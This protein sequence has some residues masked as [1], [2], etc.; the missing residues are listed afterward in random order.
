[1]SV[2]E[3]FSES[4]ERILQPGPW[5]QQLVREWVEIS[6]DV[7][8]RIAEAFA[9]RSVDLEQLS[10]AYMVNAE[11]FFGHAARNSSWTWHHL[12]SLALTSQLLQ[13]S[14][15][16]HKRID[17]LLYLGGITAVRMPKLQTFAL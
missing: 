8:P 17:D 13:D 14:P 15:Q 11:Y 3:D 12:K 7:N 10:V 6:R 1:V 9:A 5:Q 4:L 16:S 2:F